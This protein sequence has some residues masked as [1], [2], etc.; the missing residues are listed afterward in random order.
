MFS[1]I[2]EFQSEISVQTLG[3][4]TNSVLVFF[5]ILTC[6]LA[7]AL[8]ALAG[9]G[10]SALAGRLRRPARSETEKER[11]KERK[12]ERERA[13]GTRGRGPP[14]RKG[15]RVRGR[16]YLPA[17]PNSAGYKEGSSEGRSSGPSPTMVVFIHAL[18]MQS[19]L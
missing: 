9:L 6:S 12:R 1:I 18:M 3:I 15:D 16:H 14:V 10:P 17:A 4:R 7:R 11:E 2:L 13:T 5:K 19:F 8:R